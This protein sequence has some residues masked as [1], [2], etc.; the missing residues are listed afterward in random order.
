MK[1]VMG[2]FSRGGVRSKAEGG[3][4]FTAACPAQAVD[5][6]DTTDKGQM[7][8]VGNL[9]VFLFFHPCYPWLNLRVFRVF[10]L[11]GKRKREF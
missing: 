3:A 6:T 10:S 4:F 2:S 5:T 11:I 8:K 1:R 7:G 9:V